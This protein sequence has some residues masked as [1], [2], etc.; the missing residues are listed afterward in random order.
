MAIPLNVPFIKPDDTERYAVD[1][2]DRHNPKRRF[3]VPV[4]E[5]AE[6]SYGI[7]L[8]PL[9]GLEELIEAHGF[10]T[11]DFREI[12]IDRG[13]WDCPVQ[14][15]F[16]STI[17]HELGH[18]LM[19][20]GV[21]KNLRFATLDE[22]LDFRRNVAPGDLLWLEVHAN[23][24]MGR[25]LAP[26]SEIK[27]FYEER[28][29]ECSRRGL[30]TEPLDQAVVEFIVRAMAQRFHVSQKMMR[31]RLRQERLIAPDLLCTE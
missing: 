18:L 1:F 15:R 30:N 20:A 10:I 27:Q 21:Y 28:I 6:E 8:V 11:S 16:L 7:H 13:V 3:P 4:D 24:F 31:V 17:A 25:V 9:T 23:W 12:L 14:H 5:I 26:T 19:H 2:L 29:E 22:Y